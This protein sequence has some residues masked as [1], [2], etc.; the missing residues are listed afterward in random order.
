MPF[1][2]GATSNV[3]R[4]LNVDA[5]PPLQ[6][7]PE[8]LSQVVQ[9]ACSYNPNE[10]YTS[11]REMQEALE[12]DRNESISSN[13]NKDTVTMVCMSQ[14]NSGVVRRPVKGDSIYFG[15]YDWRVLE[16]ANNKMLILNNKTIENKP[17]NETWLNTTWENCTLRQYLN[18]TFLDNFS[19]HEQACIA[20]T[21]V[22]NNNNP[23]YGTAGGNTTIDK[24]FLETV[25]SVMF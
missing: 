17:Y 8:W 11:A 19:T 15:Q 4:V 1:E 13:K 7:V 18:D 25:K 6:C 3:N 5:I 2:S 12:S 20:S 9:K 24:I 10:R 22:T 16:V 21:L 14:V 23:W